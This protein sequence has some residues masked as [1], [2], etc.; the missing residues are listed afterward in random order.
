MKKLRLALAAVI[1]VMTLAMAMPANAQF[2]KFGPKVG[3]NLNKFSF[4]KSTFTDDSNRAGFTG[5]LMVEFTVPIVGVGVDLSAMYV[6]RSGEWMNE[7]KVEKVNRDY[8]EIPVNLKWKINVPVINNICRPFLTTGPS[9]AFLTSKEAISDAFKN[10]KTDVAW[11]FGF[12]VELVKHLQLH[13]SYGLGLSKT[14]TGILPGGVEGTSNIE[15]KNRYWTV[16][17]AWLF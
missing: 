16:T 10:K 15:G 9:F 6:R 3:L 5:G 8:F 14:V 7:Q 13:A 17:A 1:A 12:G 2:F 4:D 11:N